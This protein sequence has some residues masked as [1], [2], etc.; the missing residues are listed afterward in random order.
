MGRHFSESEVSAMSRNKVE[1]RGLKER[2]FRLHEERTMTYDNYAKEKKRVMDLLKLNKRTSGNIEAEFDDYDVPEESFKH[3]LLSRRPW[4]CTPKETTFNVIYREATDPA[5]L[6]ASYLM[7]EKGKK[8][9]SVS[10]RNSTKSAQN[11]SRSL[12]VSRQSTRSEPLN[13][14]QFSHNTTNLRNSVDRPTT[15]GN[16]F[17]TTVVTFHNQGSELKLPKENRNLQPIATV[18]V[19]DTTREDHQTNLEP[20]K[21]ILN[22]GDRTSKTNEDTT[23]GSNDPSYHESSRHHHST[24]IKVCKSST[25]LRHKQTEQRGKTPTKIRMNKRL[26]IPEL[27]LDTYEENGFVS[28]TIFEIG[29]TRYSLKEPMGSQEICDKDCDKTKVKDENANECF[30]QVSNSEDV[31]SGTTLE[32]ENGNEAGETP[33]EPADRQM[34]RTS[35][36][37]GADSIEVVDFGSVQNESIEKNYI[38]YKGKVIHNYVK[39]QLR[40]KYDPFVAKSR[41]KLLRKLT[42]DIPVYLEEEKNSSVKIHRMYSKGARK[43]M[44]KQLI[45]DNNSKN[46]GPCF[47]L[48]NSKIEDKMKDFF[49][50]ISEFCRENCS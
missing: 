50:S 10:R 22:L 13:N 5:I 48:E 35:T 43:R 19:E 4:S 41:E 25:S 21:G 8:I 31:H 32:K 45:E 28:T 38:R 39:P 18:C 6:K 12:A 11:G 49:H 27:T 36:T 29:D 15:V 16:S 33:L 34:S 9:H 14:R 44:L 3:V 30:N 37:A 23:Q 1:D 17:K 7:K 42:T 46:K 40:Y 47:N 26:S 20:F 2:L 24:M